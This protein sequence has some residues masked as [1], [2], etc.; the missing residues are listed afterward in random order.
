MTN[1][2]V[3]NLKVPKWCFCQSLYAEMLAWKDFKPQEPGE[4]F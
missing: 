2:V 1:C 3:V 4:G